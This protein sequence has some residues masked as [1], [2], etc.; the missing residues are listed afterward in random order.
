MTITK[1][2]IITGQK[3]M[4][5]PQYTLIDRVYNCIVRKGNH[6]YFLSSNA[7]SDYTFD[8]AATSNVL[9]IQ[10]GKNANLSSLDK[11]LIQ[12]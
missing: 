6:A 3:E 8:M 12:I 11:L 7:F 10:D 2:K 5:F 9:V 1:K 4:Y